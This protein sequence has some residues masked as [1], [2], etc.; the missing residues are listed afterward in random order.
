MLDPWEGQ[1]LST[2]LRIES[3]HR[4]CV[5]L[6]LCLDLPRLRQ[7]VVKEPVLMWQGNEFD[8]GGRCLMLLNVFNVLCKLLQ[9]KL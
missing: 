9:G 6:E 8:L 3:F 4:L 5:G 1:I 7:C 2:S